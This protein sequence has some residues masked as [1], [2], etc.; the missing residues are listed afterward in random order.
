MTASR[1]VGTLPLLVIGLGVVAALAGVLWFADG[2]NPA[3]AQ[4]RVNNAATGLPRIV[5]SAESPGIL[6][7]DTWDIR[8]ADGLPYG[9][10][11][12]KTEVG[13]PDDGR[14]IFD[15]SYQWI[16]VDGSNE[17]NVGTDSQRYQLVEADFGKKFKVRVSFTDRDDNAE[18]VT[19]VP[20]GPIA[21]PTLLSPSSLVSNT[22]SF[23]TTAMITSDY[24]MKF[25]LRSHGQGYEISSVSIDLAAV[26]SSLSVSLWTGGP[27]GG[28]A[29]V[30]VD[31]GRQHL[32]DA[33]CRQEHHQRVRDGVR[34][35]R[36]RAGL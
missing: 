11:P 35:G 21:E 9:T 32:P 15:F 8:D 30:G 2:Q 5:V 12:G 19:S 26:P 18:A 22:A 36:P 6:A 31:A 17:T 7:A 20:F 33:R 27:P 25:N 10:A 4:A 29:A 24:A 34:A 16:R 23:A 1:R 28:A 14:F 3:H 13:D